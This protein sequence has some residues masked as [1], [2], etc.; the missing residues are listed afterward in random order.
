MKKQLD[1]AGEDEQKQ[2][3]TAQKEKY[4]VFYCQ[5]A[6]PYDHLKLADTYLSILNAGYDNNFHP[7]SFI[8]DIFRPP[9]LILI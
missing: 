2:A 7:S 5:C 4:E 9:K 3:P 8:S 6:K 1:K